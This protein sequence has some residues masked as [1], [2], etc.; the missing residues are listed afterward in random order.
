MIV[1][2]QSFGFKGVQYRITIS[3]DADKTYSYKLFLVGDPYPIGEGCGY[4][5]Q[6]SAINE[7]KCA[8]LGIEY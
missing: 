3:L 8:E 1:K 7:G 6:Q 4:L 2:R 5:S